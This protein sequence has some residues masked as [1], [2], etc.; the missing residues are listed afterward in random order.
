[1]AAVFLLAALAVREQQHFGELDISALAVSCH[2]DNWEV[3][4]FRN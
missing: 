2:K 4:D 3:A 1:M